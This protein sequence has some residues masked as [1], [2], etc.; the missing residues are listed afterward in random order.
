MYDV[1][2][3]GK[4]LYPI[5]TGIVTMNSKHAENAENTFFPLNIF[6]YLLI[7]SRRKAIFPIVCM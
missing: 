7:V 1:P 6:I 2:S 4:I 5:T 3:P